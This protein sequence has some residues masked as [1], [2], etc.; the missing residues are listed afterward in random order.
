MSL[1]NAQ[2]DSIE[3]CVSALAES[4]MSLI[5]ELR[6]RFPGVTFVRCSTEDLDDAPYRTGS[7]YRLYLIDCSTACIKLT[8][9]L[10]TAD[11]VVVAT[12]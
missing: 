7:G 9:N 10:G 11:G 12:I 1:N 3:S 5:P 8:R 4:G 2:I 6:V